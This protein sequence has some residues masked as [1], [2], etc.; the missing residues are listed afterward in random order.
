MILLAPAGFAIDRSLIVQ[1]LKT[2]IVGDLAYHL[3]GRKVI[4]DRVDKIY[5]PGSKHEAAGKIVKDYFVHHMDSNPCTLFLLFLYLFSYFI[6][7]FFVAYLPSLLATIRDFPMGDMPE[8]FYAVGAIQSLPVLLIWV[9]KD[10]SFSSFFSFPSPFFFSF[11]FSFLVFFLL[12]FRET[13]MRRYPSLKRRRWRPR[14]PM[15]DWRSFLMGRT[16]PWY[17]TRRRFKILY[18]TGY[19]KQTN[20]III[21][22]IIQL[23]SYLVRE[24]LLIFFLFRSRFRGVF[25][26]RSYIWFFHET[27]N[28]TKQKEDGEA[29]EQR[30]RPREY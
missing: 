8:P 15:P 12:L 7:Y 22:S 16:M 27:Q 13:K 14:C 4:L 2:P 5:P 9:C 23:Q 19:R 28:E 11:S 3:T 20:I 24:L 1:V 10:F 30:R 29:R 6:L 18:S 26:F 21:I 17:T 25:A